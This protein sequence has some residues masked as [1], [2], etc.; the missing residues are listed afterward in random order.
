MA[1]VDVIIP[2]YNKAKTIE[3]T[4][5][6]IQ[7]QTFTDWTVII[8]D[9]GSTDD[10]AEQVRQIIDDRITLIQQEN[11]GPGAARN[12]GIKEATAEYVAFLDAD[13]EWYPWYLENAVKA[14]DTDDIGFVGT[15]YYEWPKQM[16]MTRYWQKRGVYEGVYAVDEQTPSEQIE[17]WALFFHVGTTVV[18]RQITQAYDGFYD[19]GKCLSGE[20]TIFFAKLVLN[21]KFKIITPAAVRHNRQDSGLAVTH[22]HR[23]MPILQD[24]EILMK[25]CPSNRQS[26]A[27]LF[28]ARLALRVAHH[29]ARNGF[30]SD[31]KFLVDKFPEMA[32]FKFEYM[33]CR[34]EIQLSRW[35]PYW[36]AFR[37]IVGPR[38]RIFLRKTGYRLRVLQKPPSIS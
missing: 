35:L 7:N 11:A 30:K 12:R 36:V 3:R 17:S 13:D 29:K 8:V 1:V 20:D 9:D 19:K 25:Y 26:Q 6:S 23:I 33:K 24:P 32:S 18:K 34:L 27:R 10:S 14:F 5:S 37:R 22:S 15:M 21:E 28:L 2:L 16:D 31:A 4:I 38:V